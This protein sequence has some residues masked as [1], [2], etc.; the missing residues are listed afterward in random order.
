MLSEEQSLA[1]KK[2]QKWLKNTQSFHT[3]SKNIFRLF[4]NAGT[5]KST[6][7]KEL[8]ESTKLRTAFCA[9]T[10]KAAMVLRKKGIKATT[11]HSLIY[12]P[13]QD[14]STGEVKFGL[15]PVL[16]VDLIIIDECS[17]VNEHLLADLLSFGIPL[18]A[19]GDPDQ[20]PPVE[21]HCTLIEGEPDFRLTKIHRQALDSPIL[22][23]ANRILNGLP[24]KKGRYNDTRVMTFD[25]FYNHQER[26]LADLTD[27]VPCGKNDT[28]TFT[29]QSIREFLGF[30]DCPLPEPEEKLVC[31]KN[32]GGAVLLY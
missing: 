12:E 9:Y 21:G 19:L 8:M 26:Y 32:A 23:L 17:M 15:R 25:R 16:N 1:L 14:P 4:G 10:G 2:I 13:N 3:S 24:L 29:N 22:Y 31:L 30:R 11:I 27:Q 20:L 5:G 18:L 7:A 28:R 6:L